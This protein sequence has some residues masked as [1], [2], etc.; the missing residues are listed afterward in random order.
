M[1]LCVFLVSCQRTCD[2][3]LPLV[4]LVVTGVVCN[5]RR[6]SLWAVVDEHCDSNV[7]PISRSSRRRPFFSQWRWV[8]S[9]A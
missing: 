6:V 7:P 2:P 3:V 5:T 9:V 8:F 1:I 4:N